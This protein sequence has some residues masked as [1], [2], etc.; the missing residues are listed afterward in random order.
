MA[1][2]SLTLFVVDPTDTNAPDVG[3][4]SPVED[5]VIR[6]PMA[7]VGTANDAHLLSYQL[8]VA[9][10]GS[11][12]FTQFASGSAPV[13]DGVLGMF[14]PSGLANDTYVLRL[15]AVNAGGLTSRIETTVNVAGDLKL[16]NFTLSF[17]DLTVPIAGIPITVA[18]TYDSLNAGTSSD[19]G[20]GWRLEYRDT[21]L[22][23]SVPLTGEEQFGVYNPFRDNTR[24]YLTLPGGKREGFTFKPQ[25][26]SGFAGFFG[27]YNPVFVADPGVT[28][29][30]SVPDNVTLM[31]DD[32]GEYSALVNGGELAYNPQDN[33]NFAGQYTL[34]TKDG[35]AYTVDAVTGL[36]D[37]IADANSNTL[38]FHD[39]SI[40]SSTG[41]RVTFE[42]D[43]QGR[44]TAVIDPMGGKIQYQ[45]D[46]NGD[47]VAVTD[48][49]GNTTQFIYGSSRS[50][51]LTQVIDPLGRTG[52]RTEYDDQ[53][54]LN[55]MIDAA[56]NPVQL[57]Y[58]PTHSLETVT[59][60]L[61]NPTTYEYDDLGNVVTE[62]DAKGG[63][64]R[65]TY[66]ANNNMLTETDPL[67]NTTSYTYDGNGNILTETDPLGH[68]T[69]STYLTITP[70]LFERIRGARS[71]TLLQTTTDPL[72]NTTTN[73][74]DAAG[75][76]IAT[77]DAQDNVTRYTYDTAG[78]QTSIT[79]ATGSVT[80]FQYDAAGHLMR[81]IDALGNATLFT[82]DA[83]G[84]QLTQTLTVTTPTGPR[85]QV[86]ATQY[87]AN[88]Q[89]TA[90]TDANGNTT[91]TEYDALGH[92]TATIDA[93]GH[94]TEFHYDDR[95]Q[96]VE[97]DFPD[98]TRTSET[99]DAAGHR[100]SSSDQAGRTTN[101]VYDVLGRLITTI[102]P[103][104]TPNDLTDNPQTQTQ[105]DQAGRVT[106]QIDELGNKTQFTYDAAGHQIAVEDALGDTTQTAYD[107]AGR[108]ISQTDPLG[109]TTQF[110]YDALG[111][112]VQ[113]L[114]AD[115]TKTQTTYDTLGRVVAQTD[116]AGH[117]TRDEY[118]ALGHL[119]AV[120]DAL[121]QRTEYTYDEAGDLITQK[122][123]NGHV[124]RY[125]YDALGRRT[126]TVLPLGQRSTTVYDAVGN[127]AST[128]DFNGQTIQFTYDINNRLL[129]R[130]LP[131]GTSFVFTYTPTGQRQTV[132]DSRGTTTYVY[133]QR[134][135]LLSRTD[136]DGTTIS[137]TYDAAGNRTSV[138]IPTGTTA[139][140]FDAL[141]R[142]LTVTDPQGGQTKYTYDAAGNLVRTDLPN[143]TYEIRQ[144]DALNRLAFLDNE[145]PSGTISSYRYALDPTGNRT[146][147]VEDT[148]RRVDYTYDALFRLT[149]EKITDSV[150]GNRDIS[151]VYDPVGNRLIRK[152]SVEGE[153]DY[154][155]DANDRLL[156]ETLAGIVTQYTYD[157]NGNTLS[158]IKDATDQAFYHWNAENQLIVADVTDTSGTTHVDYQYDADGI[159]VSST[160]A[161][162]ETR[163]L[164][165]TV[166][167]YAEVLLEYRPSGLTV[168][169][170]AYGERLLSQDRGGVQSFYQV[171]G[172]GSTRALTNG[173]G[174]VTDR[175]VY[176]A[177]GRTIGQVGSTPSVYLFGGEQR[178]S[179]IGLDYLRARYLS[180]GVGRFYGM[181][182]FQGSLLNP[183][184]LDRFVYVIANPVNNLDHSGAVTLI[185]ES[186]VTSLLNVTSLIQMPRFKFTSK[187]ASLFTGIF[188][189]TH[190]VLSLFGFEHA[191]IKIVVP[192][193]DPAIARHP[194][195]FLATNLDQY[196]NRYTTIGAGPE[197]GPLGLP[198]GALLV[199]NRNRKRDL[200]PR[201]G[202]QPKTFR[203]TL[204]GGSSSA[205]DNL[206]EQLLLLDDGYCD[207][208]PYD[209]F[210][211]DKPNKYNS[212]SFAA[213]LLIAAD[214]PIP[215]DLY[216]RDLPGIRKPVPS[217]LF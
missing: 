188:V 209:L 80:Q 200:D 65:R 98:G 123:A 49:D 24:V 111:R 197:D 165:D 55:K 128:T 101:Y 31:R 191:S 43:P 103:D 71:V 133:D 34:T 158:K 109:H 97:T 7:V 131:D 64:T 192:S 47:L 143:H 199:S 129:S 90:V 113:T 214:I 100:T 201:Q 202:G 20:Y 5:Q 216:S 45:Y 74:Y 167:P 169:S 88:G 59:D 168:V 94:R 144:Y 206:I 139:Y 205:I 57:S 147:V 121:G 194:S 175:Y 119:T 84:N 6:A 66:D 13:V 1:Q 135:R 44:I 125:E 60:A 145:G 217:N 51:Y 21:N 14:D 91:R 193:G 4:T 102:F 86:T 174:L 195:D 115:G 62:I 50:H 142:L 203:E 148:G 70:G 9:P 137:Y 172:L 53:G 151:Y 204:Y 75:N 67:G 104:A 56:G 30:L 208:L 29:Q 58:D 32:F 72:G 112:V 41:Q 164:I 159:R 99:Y 162:Q 126:A 8:E 150:N 117:T 114:Y 183:S 130:Q 26:Q 42:R 52:V 180:V 210:P 189:Q 63:I 96:L 187:L 138:T 78:N 153:T 207:C 16:G 179:T 118:D 15:T 17:T 19:F 155:Y 92:E 170:Y 157:D 40:D 48:R 177:F 95:G 178:D 110:V 68:V 2:A 28:D 69:R 152:D 213:G 122:D 149:D 25:L 18:R 23:T 132:V 61:G 77:T 171:D 11:D 39:M 22:T 140:T 141:N 161:G 36:L 33:L 87:N 215:P 3:I 107:A 76:L 10:M 134:D 212:N 211:D 184:T 82:Y 81:Q 176:D 146:A 37:A 124:T 105:Y 35:T 186:A 27:F 79:D 116:Q 198:N 196:G 83:N 190:K 163:Y 12:Q 182:T 127:V 160:V 154:A 156:T 185:E 166:Q 120:V 106:A 54:R 89:P 181:D 73:S 93:L 136:P 108:Q 46:P 38:T 85:T 173:S